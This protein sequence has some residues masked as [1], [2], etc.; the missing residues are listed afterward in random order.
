MASERLRDTVSMSKTSTLYTR[1]KQS[2]D[3]M[4]IPYIENQQNIFEIKTKINGKQIHIYGLAD[5]L[6]KMAVL[7][8]GWRLSILSA[9]FFLIEIDK[10]ILKFI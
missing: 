8:R 9:G 7:P 10:L 2:E 1:S 6:I 5:N 4:E 3:E